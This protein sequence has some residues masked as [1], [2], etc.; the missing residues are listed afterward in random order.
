MQ[1]R[2]YDLLLVHIAQHTPHLLVEHVH[3]HLQVLHIR[4]HATAPLLLSAHLRHLDAQLVPLRERGNEPS[5]LFLPLLPDLVQLVLVTL[6]RLETLIQ[7][8]LHLLDLVPELLDAGLALP[9]QSL[10]SADDFLVDLE[11]VLH[12]ADLLLVHLHS[13]AQLLL[14]PHLQLQLQLRRHL[15]VRQRQHFVLE[16]LYLQGQLLGKLGRLVV[17]LVH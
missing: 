11:Q 15:L 17:G 3:L 12:A 2:Q 10:L 6:L 16:G 4:D 13:L 14:L 5:V 1:T 8:R 9:E 7:L